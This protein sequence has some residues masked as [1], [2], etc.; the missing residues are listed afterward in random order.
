MTPKKQVWGKSYDQ[1]DD[2][3]RSNMSFNVQYSAPWVTFY[4]DDLTSF[5]LDL[6]DLWIK[7]TIIVQFV[8]PF[9]DSYDVM[10]L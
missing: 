3:V 9:P 5:L 10:I 4:E 7:H 1:G 6:N 2:Q 8:L